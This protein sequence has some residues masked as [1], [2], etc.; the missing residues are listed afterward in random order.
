MTYSDALFSI[1]RPAY[2]AARDESLS[3]EQRARLQ[4]I[5]LDLDNE[6]ADALAAETDPDGQEQGGD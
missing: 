6:A 2:E 4:E 5:A 3:E 1:V